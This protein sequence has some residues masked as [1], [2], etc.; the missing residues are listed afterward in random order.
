MKYFFER[1]FFVP[2]RQIVR[3]WRSYLSVFLT[4]IVLMILVISALELFE[5]YWL[6]SVEDTSVGT[7]HVVIL[8]QLYDLTE[9]IE[10][11]RR[12]ESVDAIPAGAYLSASAA[13]TS[14]AQVT[15]ET[16]AI[17]EKL[18]VHYLWG[19]PY[20]RRRDFPAAQPVPFHERTAGRRGE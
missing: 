18:D 6:R 14:P 8:G 13:L 12:V 2:T 19:Q 7:H 9:K 1:V 4:S 5:A 20:R 11:N 3:R 17:D 10:N 15:V 16:D